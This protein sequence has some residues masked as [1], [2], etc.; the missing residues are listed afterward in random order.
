MK[1]I[2]KDFALSAVKTFHFQDNNIYI[3]DSV[4][5]L[6]EI[7][8]QNSKQDNEGCGILMCSIDKCTNDVYINHATKPQS[9][10]IRK[11]AYFFLKD[12]KHQEQLDKIHKESNGTVFLC[13]TWHSHPE[14]TP[15][16][17]RLDIREW[18]KF[19]K[20]NSGTIKHFYFIIVGR[21]ELAL[22]T[23]TEKEIKLIS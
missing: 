3:G 18:K 20:G 15:R 19:I 11:Y 2:N 16:A 4:I 14:D 8:E 23:Y 12:K 1:S 21:K 7:Y 10:D 9:E 6:F 17:S 13:G 22:Y 5:D